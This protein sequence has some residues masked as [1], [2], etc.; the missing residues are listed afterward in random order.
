MS[1]HV[2]RKT[3]DF[4]IG[5]P[6]RTKKPLSLTITATGGNGRSEGPKGPAVCV[7]LEITHQTGDGLKEPGA[8]GEMPP[9]L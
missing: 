5:E 3:S 9:S 8:L 6:E 7:T 1:G 2:L 4:L